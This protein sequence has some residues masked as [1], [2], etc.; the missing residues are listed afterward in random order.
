LGLPQC[1]QSAECTE[2]FDAAACN[3]VEAESDPF[4]KKHLDLF[5]KPTCFSDK[6]WDALKLE[7]REPDILGLPRRI[8]KPKM[9]VANWLSGA[10]TT[11]VGRL[12]LEE[13]MG[14]DALPMAVKGSAS[15][16]QLVA[17]KHH[18]LN[19]ELWNGADKMINLP[20]DK[21]TEEFI[22]SLP[23]GS[24]GKE[25]LFV[26][27]FAIEEHGWELG[28]EH[29]WSKK[30]SLDLFSKDGYTN[31]SSLKVADNAVC[32][33][34]G[35]Q[36]GF[37]CSEDG[38]K[39]PWSISNCTNGKFIPPPCLPLSV[40]KGQNQ[41][42]RVSPHCAE[43]L[44][45]YPTWSTGLFEGVILNKK[46]NF[47]LNYVGQHLEAELKSRFAKKIPTIYYWWEPDPLL[48]RYPSTFVD[49]A[50]EAGTF[51][52]EPTK[53]TGCTYKQSKALHKIAMGS[54]KT[55]EPDLWDFFTSFQMTNEW[56]ND[57]MIDDKKKSSQAACDWLHANTEKWKPWVKN[58]P[59]PVKKQDVTTIVIIA[60]VSVMI[61]CAVVIVSAKK[62]K[63][64]VAGRKER[65][66]EHAAVLEFEAACREFEDR[67]EDV[68]MVNKWEAGFENG[69]T[70]AQ[71]RPDHQLVGI[72]T[73]PLKNPIFTLFVEEPAKFKPE[74][75]FF[76]DDEMMMFPNIKSHRRS[77]DGTAAAMSYVHY[78]IIPKRRIYNAV[79][80]GPA[81]IPLLTRMMKRG[82]LALQDATVR[83]YY[84]DSRDMDFDA[85]VFDK[86]MEHLGL[87]VQVHPKHSVGHLHIHCCLTNLWTVNGSTMKE[88]NTRLQ[89]VI[90]A[91]KTK[92][93]RAALSLDPL[94]DALVVTGGEKS[95][96]SRSAVAPVPNK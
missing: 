81:D 57:M 8:F 27:K 15:A 30:A 13:F 40:E 90:A 18:H 68:R 48:A 47:T 33:T 14:Y 55:I 41:P 28:N 50:C 96:V 82:M 94:R 10:L 23:T 17:Y 29:S 89:D 52:K 2:T 34:T 21:R 24:S 78:L 61:L 76:E 26:P 46:W 31:C 84:N 87:F 79:S 49:V 75:I 58:P 54:L 3:E 91:L 4:F 51:D 88:K 6:K 5:A 9:S 42:Y 35:P 85:S 83:K 59:A 43:W 70:V 95:N 64:H 25:G 77:E 63:E 80:L 7:L 67:E 39:D 66:R 16:V 93:P 37:I 92:K 19:L 1:A 74:V 56:L 86:G 12:V 20:E 22:H 72:H 65:I 45:A 36:T 69:K 11:E 62:Y 44:L 60:V 53:A 32:N 71:D 38:N 73:G